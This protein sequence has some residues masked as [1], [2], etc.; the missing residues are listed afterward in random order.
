ML[1]FLCIRIFIIAYFGDSCILKP[2]F[3]NLQHIIIQILDPPSL[4]PFKIP[5]SYF[6]VSR[7][8]LVIASLTQKLEYYELF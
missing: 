8:N 5:F 2:F 4:L 3:S 1:H 7:Y 6:T